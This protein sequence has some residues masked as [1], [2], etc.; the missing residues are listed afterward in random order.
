MGGAFVAVADDATA[1]Y[2]NP[3]GFKSGAL[4]SAVVETGSGDIDPEAAEGAGSSS[5][6]FVGLGSWPVGVSYY[7]IRE[8]FVSAGTNGPRTAGT[9]IAHQTALTVLQSFTSRVTVGAAAKFIRGIAATAPVLPGVPPE[10]PLEL[11]ENLVGVGTNR[12]DLDLGVMAEVGLSRVGLVLRNVL[13]PDFPTPTGQ[14]LELSRQVRVGWAYV[15]TADL[16]VA[17]D[18]DLTTTDTP[19][20]ER[21]NIAA[22]VE[23]WWLTTRRRMGLR[24]GARVSTV[25]DARPSVAAGGSLSVWAGLLAEG[26]VTL[27]GDGADRGWTLGVRVAF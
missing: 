19:L 23:R 21:R 7:R 18:A 24:G 25:G 1:G 6:T 11:V 4:F 2:W 26:Q 12:F 14:D 3:A 9:L 15:P 16:V 20:G 5:T 13:R 22:G 27:G 8:S 17:V 10:D